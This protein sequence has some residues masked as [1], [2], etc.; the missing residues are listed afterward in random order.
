VKRTKPVK[1]TVTEE[2]IKT[3][4]PCSATRC[5]VALA[6][7]RSLKVKSVWTVSVAT[8][9]Y[10]NLGPGGY[11]EAVRPPEVHEFASR[12]DEGFPVEPFSFTLDLG[13]NLA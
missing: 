9:I 2:D 1:I 3:G 4:E 12:F 10:V 8:M 5:P 6:V 7:R 11:Y 13:D